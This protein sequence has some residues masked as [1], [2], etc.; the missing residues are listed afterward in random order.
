[1]KHL[2]DNWRAIRSIYA[3]KTGVRDYIVENIPRG[4]IR[5]VEDVNFTGQTKEAMATALE[6]QTRRATARD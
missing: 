5:G 1:V 4:G 6:E 2:Q 3:D